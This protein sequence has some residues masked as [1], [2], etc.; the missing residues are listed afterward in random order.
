MKFVELSKNLKLGIDKVYRLT[1]DDS[2]LI[3][4]AINLIKT[5]VVKDF[6]EFN[7]IKYESDNLKPEDLEVTLQTLP[8]GCD[9]K[10]IV[11]ELCNVDVAHL[12]NSYNFDNSSAVLI[13]VNCEK[14]NVG[15]VVDCQKL[16][17]KDIYRYVLNM[18]VKHNLSIEERALDY[19][20]DATNSDMSRI[21]NELQ[22][23][24][25]YCN[26]KDVVKIEDITNLVFNSDEYVI[27]MLTNALDENNLTKFQKV[28]TSMTKTLS[29]AE[30]FAYI[31][32]YFKKM[33]YTS[34]SKN[35][36]ELQKILAVKPY[37]IKVMRDNVKKNGKNYY[38]ELYNKYIEL[39]YQIKS[40]EISAKNAM[41]SL[42]F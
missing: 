25:A 38:I 3:H 30:V 41:Y 23:I 19:L 8:I 32:K 14:V 20:I 22:K 24:I 36:D 26:G 9:Y 5:A 35:D 6:E 4:Q 11:I 33:F 34:I 31:G 15:V 21:N 12:I 1:G 42:V 27:Y 10:L 16:D 29:Y 37:A 40:G 18:L 28:L 39:D 17:K 13:C 7:Y 2:F